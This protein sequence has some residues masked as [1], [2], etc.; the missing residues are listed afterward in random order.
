MTNTNPIKKIEKDVSYL[1]TKITEHIGDVGEDAHGLPQNGNAGMIP[2]EIY[3]KVL[4]QFKDRKYVNGVDIT[5]LEPDLYCGSN[6]T[7]IP[8]NAVDSAE[9]DA[10]ALID[11]SSYRNGKKQII[12]RQSWSGATWIKNIHVPG[13]SPDSIGWQKFST[14]AILWNGQVSRVGTTIKLAEPKN[15]FTDLLVQFYGPASNMG[16]VFVTTSRDHYSLDVT[17]I[18]DTTEE[19]AV[20]FFPEAKLEFGTSQTACKLTVNHPVAIKNEASY[21]TSDSNLITITKIIG[22]NF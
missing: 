2:D 4:H 17:N 10:L 6:L 20:A 11:V 3:Q 7:G 12:Y 5:T 16:S 13:G 21:D 22:F 9:K 8:E 1:K 15:N 18:P 19:E 14:H